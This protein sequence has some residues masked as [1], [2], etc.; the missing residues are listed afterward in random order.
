MTMRLT[1]FTLFVNDHDQAL[2]FYVD[3][4]GFV[5]P[6]DNGRAI[7]DG[8]WCARRRPRTSPSTSSWPARR[9]SRFSWDDRQLLSRLPNHDGSWRDF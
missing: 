8:S 6:E 4:L 5:V 3:R 9:V 7:T 2:Q 1:V